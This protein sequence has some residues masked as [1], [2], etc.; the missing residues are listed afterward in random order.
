MKV[1]GHVISVQNRQALVQVPREAHCDSCGC[2]E[3]ERSACAADE[4]LFITASDPIG[5]E[6]GDKVEVQFGSTRMLGT[7]LLVFWLPLLMGGVGYALGSLL[8]E[9]LWGQPSEGLG[10]LLAVT[11]LVPSVF[12]IV[13]V[14]RK[15][16]A[17]A[18]GCR[19]TR[20]L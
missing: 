4:A 14:E 11:T 2:E 17:S 9:A 1:I 6:R 3:G 19:I 8:G 13:R 16:R 12:L 15:S 7:I 10:A 18:Q 5:V 20:V